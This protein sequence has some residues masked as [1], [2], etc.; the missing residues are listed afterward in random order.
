MEPVNGK[1]CVAVV[2]V[3]MAAVLMGIAEVAILGIAAGFVFAELVLALLGG[4]Q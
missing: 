4:E 1:A 3:C 2:L